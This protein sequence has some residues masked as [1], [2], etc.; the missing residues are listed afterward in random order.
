MTTEIVGVPGTT[1][2]RSGNHHLSVSNGKTE[3]SSDFGFT[4]TTII[5]QSCASESG[6]AAQSCRGRSANTMLFA[7][8]IS[9]DARAPS[10]TS[11]SAL[12]HKD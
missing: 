7:P 1:Y 12:K 9:A 10:S 11:A 5:F 4:G 3:K 8:A 2:P 6:W